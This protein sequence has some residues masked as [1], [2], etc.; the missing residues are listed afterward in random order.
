MILKLTPGG[1]KPA[2]ASHIRHSGVDPT[3]GNEPPVTTVISKRHS[4]RL[5]ITINPWR[6][7]KRRRQPSSCPPYRPQHSE[8]GH[9]KPGYTLVPQSRRAAPGHTAITEATNL[10]SRRDQK[11]RPASPCGSEAPVL[12]RW[13]DTSRC[14]V[15]SARRRV[16]PL[17]PTHEMEQDKTHT[18]SHTHTH[19]H[20][21]ASS[22]SLSHSQAPVITRARPS[23]TYTS[24]PP[25]WSPL[26]LD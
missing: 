19:T 23:P 25:V 14:S 26:A 1:E 11:A 13:S 2:T 16:S 21:E 10:F 4:P 24:F 7:R 15:T 17:E 22:G 6:L 20:T 12:Q 18:L 3:C 5:N 9:F 8:L